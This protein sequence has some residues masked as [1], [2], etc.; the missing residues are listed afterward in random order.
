VV[1]AWGTTSSGIKVTSNAINQSGN[2]TKWQQA[3]GQNPR[4]K[5]NPPRVPIQ[6]QILTIPSHTAAKRRRCPQR[7]Y[8]SE[9]PASSHVTRQMGA[10]SVRGVQ[11]C[12]WL[13]LFNA[14]LTAPLSEVCALPDP[15]VFGLGSVC[16]C[17]THVTNNINSNHSQL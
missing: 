15:C 17:N 10:R 5:A 3:N 9:R 12:V 1:R 11:Q 2:K 16:V 8:W 6:N 4:P 7:R 14:L 13:M